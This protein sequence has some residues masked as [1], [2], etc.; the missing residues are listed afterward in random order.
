MVSTKRSKD[1]ILRPAAVIRYDDAIGCH[2][3]DAVAHGDDAVARHATTARV[4]ERTVN[5]A[6]ADRDDCLGGPSSLFGRTVIF[7]FF[8]IP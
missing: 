8:A 5:M 6:A 4:C 2:G 3:D 7:K 1:V